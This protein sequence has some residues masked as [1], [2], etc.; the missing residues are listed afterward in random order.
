MQITLLFFAT[1]REQAKTKKD[2]ID[3]PEGCTVLRLLQEILVEKYPDLIIHPTSTLVSINREF[4]G[5]E[6]IIP[7]GAEV[8]IFPP[9][10]GGTDDLPTIILLTEDK[11]EMEALIRKIT[12]PTSGASAVFTGMVR[13]I[14]YLPAYKKI[15]YLEYEA[16]RPMAETKMKQVADEIRQK[17]PMVEGIAVV[18][19]IGVLEP[20]VPTT[21]IACTSAHRNDGIFEAAQFGINRLKEIVPVWKKE[22]GETGEEW[23]EGEYTPLPHKD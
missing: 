23:I 12:L 11:I 22:A 16:Y 9:V 20:G 5:F 14:T 2:T 19:R 1:F 8:A 10:S 13:E 15:K 3:I 4:A 7:E 21:M 17:W 6:D 18:Q